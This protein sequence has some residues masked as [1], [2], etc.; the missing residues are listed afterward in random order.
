M[1]NTAKEV[2]GTVTLRGYS[3]ENTYPRGILTCTPP[4]DSREGGEGASTKQQ[5][6]PQQSARIACKIMQNDS[7][8]ENPSGPPRMSRM[9]I[10]G[11]RWLHWLEVNLA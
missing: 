8:P 1:K 9:L 10:R 3:V 6:D 5:G 11:H 4:H 2:T 7:G